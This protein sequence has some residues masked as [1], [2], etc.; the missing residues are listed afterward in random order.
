V[1]ELLERGGIEDFILHR[2]KAVDGEFSNLLLASLFDDG[3]L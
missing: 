1:K 2:V 3:F